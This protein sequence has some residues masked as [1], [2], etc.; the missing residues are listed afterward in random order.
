MGTTARVYRPSLRGQLVAVRRP[1]PQQSSVTISAVSL[2]GAVVILV[3]GPAAFLNM[4]PDTVVWLTAAIIVAFVVFAWKIAETNG[5]NPWISP[6]V[7]IMSQYLV[8]YGIGAVAAYYWRFIP[9]EVPSMR[10]AFLSGGV[11]ANLP[12]ACRLALLSACGLYIGLQR[13]PDFVAGLLPKVNWRVSESKLKTNLWICVPP[14]LLGYAWLSPYIPKSLQFIMEA[15]VGTANGMLVIGSYYLF[16]GRPG[17]RL[18]WA[19][20]IVLVYGCMLPTAARSGQMVPLL[21]P[22]LL[23]VCGYM[24]ARRRLPWMGLLISAPVVMYVVVPFVAFYK[25]SKTDISSINDRAL[26]ATEAFS[27]ATYET[28]LELAL[29]RTVVRFAGISL[30]ATFVQ[31]YPWR[32]PFDLGRSFLI[33]AAGLIPR[34]MWRNKPYET[35][36]NLYSERVGLFPPGSQT[37]M[38]FDGVS[39]YY[40]NFGDVGVFVISIAN[41]WYIAMLYTWLVR[42]GHPVIGPAIFLTLLANNWD[43]FGVVMIASG[44]IRF[45]PIWILIYYL[46]SHQKHAY[47]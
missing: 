29:E 44:Q 12:L 40:V 24:V 45:L 38:I 31:Y 20:F 1:L 42:R 21:M 11:W 6:A 14:A 9:W 35:E 39:E 25:I 3:L 17:T 34:I 47:R 32:Y 8:R 4:P 19:V 7:L 5:E 16:S 41:G 23:A 2:S 33:E 37:S 15:S 13:R 36:L 18:K 28:R 43:S 27:K 10:Q 46:M 30:P 26:L 22:G